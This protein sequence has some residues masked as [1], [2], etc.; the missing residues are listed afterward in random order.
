MLVDIILILVLA[1]FVF[2]GWKR[3]MVLTLFSL[4]SLVIAFFIASLVSPLTTKL[5]K[6][7]G[8]DESIQSSV[9]EILEEN[10]SKGIRDAADEL[11]LPSF[12]IDDIVEGTSGTVDNTLKN[13]S[14]SATD[15]ICGIIGFAIAFVAALLLLQLIKVLLKLATKLPVIKQADKIGGIAAGLLSGLVSVSIFLFILSAFVYFDFPRTVM[16]MVEDS[17]LTKFLYES[18]L[19]GKFASLLF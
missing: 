8:V 3:G 9:Y 2:I 5:V 4:F 19:I 10:A 7:T 12:M 18:N 13:V 1:I 17:T 11:P 15:V 16:E 14:E 6:V